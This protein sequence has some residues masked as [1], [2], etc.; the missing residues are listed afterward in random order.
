M[1]VLNIK[2]RMMVPLHLFLS[3]ATLSQA[4]S[5][6]PTVA[7]SNQAPVSDTRFDDGA[8]NF[9][10]GM[11]LPGF[12]PGV[13][14]QHGSLGGPIAHGGQP[15]YGGRPAYGG[16][17]GFGQHPPTT[18]HHQP[19][20]SGQPGYGGKG[21]YGQPGYG[22]QPPTTHHHQPVYS[23]Q[24]GYGGPGYGGKGGYGQPGYGH[25][26]MS[27]PVFGGA[28]AGFDGYFGGPNGGFG[29]R[30]GGKY[31]GHFGGFGRKYGR[32]FGGYGGL[33]GMWGLAG[34]FDP[35]GHGEFEDMLDDQNADDY[36]YGADP[37]EDEHLMSTS[38]RLEK[39]L[40]KQW[41]LGKRKLQVQVDFGNVPLEWEYLNQYHGVR[42]PLA[43]TAFGPK[44]G[45]A[46]P[47]APMFDYG[48]GPTGP[49][50]GF[51]G[52]DFGY[53]GPG[54]GPG[55]GLGAPPAPG[56]GPSQGPGYGQ[57]DQQQQHY[58]AQGQ[59]SPPALAQQEAQQ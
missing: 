24:P 8:V 23:G 49:I 34:Q 12:T 38:A 2:A 13:G 10:S 17:P 3:L 35:Y 4:R 48:F 58:P 20:Y 31:G 32:G 19:V 25:E 9:G 36:P 41:Q 52:P 6:T 15:A 59:Q 54:Y 51:G 46:G 11:P 33:H 1:G 53:G 27:I 30:F 56:Y 26:F 22:Q 47:P 37:E 57:P 44:Y 29:R 21:G 50:G 5:I 18:H 40:Q 55:Y 39:Y 16:Q 43:M 28:H 45:L 14:P 42:H 7:D